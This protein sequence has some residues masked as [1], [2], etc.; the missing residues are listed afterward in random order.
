MR[1]ALHDFEVTIKDSMT[2]GDMQQVQSVLASGAK[3]DAGGLKGY[4]ASA[5]LE[6]KYKALEIAIVKIEPHAEGA[7]AIP[8]SREWMNALSVEDGDILFDAVDGLGKKK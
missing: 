5:M 6:A 4:D 3:I 2:W 1:I 7:E 8:F